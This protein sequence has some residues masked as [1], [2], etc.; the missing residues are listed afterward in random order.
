MAATRE[1]HAMYST[2]H[3]ISCS[4]HVVMPYRAQQVM[5][6]VFYIY[7]LAKDGFGD[8]QECRKNLLASN[9][10]GFQAIRATRRFH[11]RCQEHWLDSFCVQSDKQFGPLARDNI[12]NHGA[13]GFFC[14]SSIA[15]CA[16][17]FPEASSLEYLY[18]KLATQQGQYVCSHEC[19]FTKT[20]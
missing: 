13:S 17:D 16:S 20:R 14:L 1:S 11:P 19:F 9:L 10:D 7:P 5:K 18:I 15:I 8:R 6:L 2:A 3:R 12:K 4:S